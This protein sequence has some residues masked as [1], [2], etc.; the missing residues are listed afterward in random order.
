MKRNLASNHK[1]KT[2]NQKYHYYLTTIT[3]ANNSKI[4]K[5]LIK[6]VLNKRIIY[7][8]LKSQNP[9]RIMSLA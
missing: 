8:V 6:K 4:R 5:H 3:T 7:Q 2:K 9:G 1:P